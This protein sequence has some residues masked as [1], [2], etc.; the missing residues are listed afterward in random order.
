MSEPFNAPTTTATQIATRRRPSIWPIDIALGAIVGDFAE[1][2]GVPGYLTQGILG[3]VPV[4]GTCC[5]ARDL[6]ANMGK[7]NRGG[8]ILNAISL[9]PVAGGISKMAHAMRGIKNATQAY[10]ATANVV[11]A[12]LKD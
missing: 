10:G 1:V 12:L 8:V 6:L 7:G 3:F 4:V 9:V 5:A 11:G 2:L